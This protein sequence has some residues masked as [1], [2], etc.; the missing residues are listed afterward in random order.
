MRTGKSKRQGA[1][2]NGEINTD[3]AF[4]MEIYCSF[5]DLFDAPEKLA[6]QI[7]RDM[8]FL[9]IATPGMPMY[10]WAMRVNAL[11]GKYVIPGQ[12]RQRHLYWNGLDIRDLMRN[13]RVLEA[14]GTIDTHNLPGYEIDHP[15]VLT[16][17]ASGQCLLSDTVHGMQIAKYT[18]RI[19]SI[20]DIEHYEVLAQ[21]RRT[22]RMLT[23][24][25][26]A[27]SG[28]ELHG[29]ENMPERTEVMRRIPNDGP[30]VLR[31]RCIYCGTAI[32]VRGEIRDG[33]PHYEIDTSPTCP[34]LKLCIKEYPDGNG[35]RFHC[36]HVRHHQAPPAFRF[37]RK[38]EAA[39]RG[40]NN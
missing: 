9:K 16:A 4:Q 34:H 10:Q 36:L 17:D 32:K 38:A 8:G 18:G 13:I 31:A 2:E 27:R 14:Y 21:R 6:E 39:K 5:P 37:L 40:R 1:L 12:I 20:I 35:G 30:A 33:R 3:D 24:A 23:P 25:T 7:N 11:K 19:A 28:Y 15:A 22:Y 29:I 26:I